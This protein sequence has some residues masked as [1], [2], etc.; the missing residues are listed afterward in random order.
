MLNKSG[1]NFWI[2]VNGISDSLKI[3]A[4]GYLPRTGIL[5][6]CV[7]VFGLLLGMALAI[8]NKGKIE[9]SLSNIATLTLNS[10]LVSLIFLIVVATIDLWS[11]ISTKRNYI[12]LLPF[13]GIV[14][15]GAITLQTHKSPT[16]SKKILGVFLVFCSV[17]LYGSF[18]SVYRKSHTGQDWRG[19]SLYLIKSHADKSIYITSGNKYDSWRYIVTNF[20]LKKFSEGSLKALPYFVDKTI[21]D[22]PAAIIF[23]HNESE[24]DDLEREMTEIGAKQSFRN[25]NPIDVKKGSV[26]VYILN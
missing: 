22:R 25:K 5:G 21:L 11:P 2:Q 18:D 23:G 10:S 12:V 16:Y 17:S 24:A 26:G 8:D 15:A 19:A 6:G 1:G 13:I 9:H 3:A 4:S 7:L 14:I 20:Y